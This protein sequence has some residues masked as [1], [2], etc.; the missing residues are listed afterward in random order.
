MC[1]ETTEIKRRPDPDDQVVTVDR[2]ER[3]PMDGPM[4][5]KG[6]QLSAILAGLIGFLC[7]VS[8]PF[9]PVTQ[10]QST[11]SWPQNGSVNS[12]DAP[13]VAQAPISLSAS[14]PLS[15]VDELPEKRA[16]LLGTLPPTA[17]S[18]TEQ[19]MQVR[20]TDDSVDVIFRN[21]VVLSLTDDEVSANRDKMLTVTSDETQTVAKVEGAKGKDGK[22][23]E[24][25]SQE[26]LRP[27]VTGIYTSLKDDATAREA[28]GDGLNVSM[29]ID[30]RYTSKPTIVKYIV[31]WLG[32]LLTLA[33][34]WT[35]WK[36]DQIDGAKRTPWFRKG[37]L[38]PRPLDWLV[39]GVLV[40]WHFIG[41]NTSD[42]GY[43]FTM[44]RVSEHSGYMANYYRWYGAPESPFG[45][46]YYD[47]LALMVKV[48][49]ASVWMRLPALVA[50]LA[51]WFVISR[52]ILPR[53]G[54]AISQRRVAYWSAAG[55]LLAFWL[56]YNNGLRP[57]PVI[58][59]MA[60]LTW[61]FIE[62]AI[63]TRRLTPAAIGVIVA[64]LALGSGPTGLMAVA[65]LIAGLPMIARIIVERHQALGGGWR[66]PLM[67]LVPFMSAGTAILV[68]VFGDQTLASVL[69]SIRVRGAIGPS[70]K[71]YEEPVRY[72]WLLLQ[73]VD[74][75]LTRRFAMLVALLALVI[76]IAALLRHRT[77]PGAL[78]G[79]ATRLVF[80]F[81]G[82]MFFLTFTPTKWTHHFGVYAGIAAVLAALAAM[83]ISHWAVGSRRNQVLFAGLTLFLMA[84]ALTGI[85]GWWYVGSY[86]V[87]WFDK[88]IQYRGYQASTFVLALA[89]LTLFAGAV[90]AFIED[91]K[92]K[93]QKPSTLAARMR[94]GT[95]AASP[96]AAISFA[97]V[98]FMLL[99]LGKAFVSQYPAYSI[100]LGNVRTLTG[101]TCNLA[102]D[103]LMETDT[104][105]GFLKPADGKLLGESLDP[106]KQAKGFTPNGVPDDMVA[107]AIWV[108]DGQSNTAKD[109]SEGGA[110]DAN[111]NIIG[112]GT[113][114]DTDGGTTKNTGV[115]K[116]KLALPFGLD[117]EKV[118]VLGSYS[119]E[120]Q[121]PSKMETSWYEL[122]ELT[123]DTPILVV[124][125]AGRIYHH[126]INGVEQQGQ[127]LVAQ[128]GRG[129]GDKF[130]VMAEAEPT[131]IGPNPV[132]RNLR[133]P[134]KDI[135]EGANA[136]RL[137]A[138]DTDLA[139]GAWL[140]VTPPRVAKLQPMTEVI[141]ENNPSIIDWPVSFQFPCQRPF[142]HYAGVAE[143]PD[144][145]IMPDRPLKV[146]GSDTWQSIAGGGPL[147]WSDAMNE[148]I[149]VPTYLKDNWALDW[150]SVE[151]RSQR[152]NDDG[153]TPDVAKI[154][155]EEVTRSGLWKPGHMIVKSE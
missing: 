65:A 49:T 25:I 148:S 68:G 20:K 93:P 79:P 154:Q 80:V 115:N 73:S 38:R 16:V 7:F 6:I 134:T 84:Y 5:S 101:N 51:T 9:L 40:L 130:E 39:T 90:F 141:T 135:P 47:L 96:I 123:E 43:I 106:Q 69:E 4:P 32:L 126:D 61:V 22:P 133:F 59:L 74:G 138:E 70:M 120:I 111:P 91:V 28:I 136:V 112:G 94:L 124:T 142:D 75:S 57:E 26:D 41:A 15:V 149:T 86:G 150:G 129:S 104:N 44:A 88:T 27:Q 99:S 31:M 37:G 72:Y 109:E 36:I 78:A 63:L 56:P 53:L 45:S 139:E 60:L 18:P 110:D 102:S 144:Y 113:G 3:P 50:G 131:D 30:S 152:K 62:R 48:S 143:L 127:K 8:L 116:S 2:V 81:A 146:S 118:P 95:I 82:T 85:N 87:P 125:A 132:W 137:V 35:L 76:T 52:L 17:K 122:P 92:G 29:E 58:A 55:V 140:S 97:M 128:Y 66:A 147:G 114:E 121:V 77:V 107:D 64:T 98:L 105:A 119:S 108:D 23:L 153:K 34:L 100:G 42:D 11:L 155:Y 46:P 67:Q 33:S 19:G 117:P 10:T 83:A 54:K 103:V 151:K 14:L 12:V 1:A 21:K 71:W 89:L 24:G 13:L 145:R